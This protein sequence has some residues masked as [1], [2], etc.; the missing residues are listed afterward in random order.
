MIVLV[1]YYKNLELYLRSTAGTR[2]IVRYV[3]IVDVD[4]VLLFFLPLVGAT[5]LRSSNSFTSRTTS[6]AKLLKV[7]EEFPPEAPKFI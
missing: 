7:T 6:Q 4:V 5:S 1:W 3:N 2:F